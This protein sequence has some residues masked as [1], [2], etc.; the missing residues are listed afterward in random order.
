LLHLIPFG[1][2]LLVRHPGFVPGDLASIG[3]IL[4]AYGM[5]CEYHFQA[6]STLK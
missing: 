6:T 2:N 4:M 1:L 5:S 3:L